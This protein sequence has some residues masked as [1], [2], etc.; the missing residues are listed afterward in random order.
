MPFSTAESSPQLDKAL[1]GLPVYESVGH[2]EYYLMLSYGAN[3]ASHASPLTYSLQ[4]N[5]YHPC[6]K[7]IEYK[8]KKTS[9]SD[10]LPSRVIA[11]LLGDIIRKMCHNNIAPL[12]F[13]A[14]DKRGAHFLREAD[15]FEGDDKIEEDDMIED[16]D[17]DRRRS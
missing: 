12:S 9:S 8:M 5:V 11:G 16:Y 13:R 6:H 2:R 17:L 3:F 15:S 7:V 1:S 10:S 4:Q 14:W